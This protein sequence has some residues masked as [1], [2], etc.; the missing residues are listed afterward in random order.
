MLSLNLKKINIQQQ[1]KYTNFALVSNNSDRAE[2]LEEEEI[3]PIDPD[4]L[5]NLVID[6]ILDREE[7]IDGLREIIKNSEK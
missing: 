6:E 3:I 2:I 7:V 1:E 4:Y 5:Q